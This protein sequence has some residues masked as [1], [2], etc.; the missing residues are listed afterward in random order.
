VG[1]AHARSREAGNPP[2]SPARKRSFRAAAPGRDSRLGTP[3]RK[4]PTL[5][6]TDGHVVFV[7]GLIRWSGGTRE[8]VLSSRESYGN[9]V[10]RGPPLRGPAALPMST[11]LRPARGRRACSK[12]RRAPA[13]FQTGPATRPGVAW[14]RRRERTRRF[15]HAAPRGC[16][17]NDSERLPCVTHREAASSVAP[18][19][20]HI[21]APCVLPSR[22]V[23]RGIHRDHFP[24]RAPRC[25]G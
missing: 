4:S 13:S 3:L 25:A 7:H 23:P 5:A 8:A 17:E 20:R 2:F 19:C 11:R 9:R 18:I 1:S 15:A 24:D 21:E 12:F 16:P 22:H 14:A 10:R 6:W